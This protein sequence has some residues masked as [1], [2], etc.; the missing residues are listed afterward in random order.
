M[1]KNEFAVDILTD[2][3]EDAADLGTY[4]VLVNRV[5]PEIRPD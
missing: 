5:P 2:G 3:A 1:V 4:W